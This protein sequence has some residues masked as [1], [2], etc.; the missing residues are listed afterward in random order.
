MKRLTIWLSR[1]SLIALTSTH[2][3][4]MHIFHN[5]LAKYT[6]HIHRYLYGSMYHV[7]KSLILGPAEHSTEKLSWSDFESLTRDPIQHSDEHEG[8]KKRN[9]MYDGTVIGYV[10]YRNFIRK[11]V[12]ILYLSYIHI[13]P[14]HRN[15][16]FGSYILEQ[17]ELD[18]RSKDT[19]E[20]EFD[21]VKKAIS[22]YFKHGF[23][24]TK[25]SLND[26]EIP[27]VKKLTPVSRKGDFG[28]P[29]QLT[30]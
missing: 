24:T 13:D 14:K 2:I 18:A 16:G 10:C 21:S 20:I 15:K 29:T 12:S 27:M 9:I 8:F 4:A 22:L 5:N 17:I 23:I 6:A 19:M 11:N 1:A 25:H 30:L 3:H 7:R 26:T 28:L